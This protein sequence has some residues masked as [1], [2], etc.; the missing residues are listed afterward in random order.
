[1]RRQRGIFQQDKAPPPT[2][3]LNETEKSDLP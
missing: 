1:M 2:Q 3:I